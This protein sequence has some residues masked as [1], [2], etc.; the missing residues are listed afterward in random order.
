MTARRGLFVLVALSIAMVVFSATVTLRLQQVVAITNGLIESYD[1]LDRW[2][3]ATQQTPVDQQAVVR[4]AN[5]VVNSLPSV[6]GEAKRDSASFIHFLRQYQTDETA[7]ANAA[8]LKEMLVWDLF[9]CHRLQTQYSRL[10]SLS[11]VGLSILILCI[12]V[13][14]YFM[15]RRAQDYRL[16][17]FPEANPNPVFGL[18]YRGELIYTNVAVHK[19]VATYLGSGGEPTQ[20]LPEGY[21]TQLQELVNRHQLHEVWVHNVHE[22]I[23][24][25][26]LQLLPKH[27]RIHIYAED[28]TE[29]E[30]IRARNAFI[31]Y[32]DPVC[33]L[34]NRQKLEQVIDQSDDPAQPLTLVMTFVSGMS[35]VLSTQGLAVADR[36]A[37]EF[38][39]RLRSAYVSVLTEQDSKPLVFRF[40]ANLF[41]CLYQG[42]L[43]TEVH[44]R[45]EKALDQTVLA[46]F[47]FGK[48]DYFFQIQSGAAS[49]PASV[50]AR[51]LIQRVNLALHSINGCEAVYRVYDHRI[52][53]DIQQQQR[54]EQ[55]LRRAVELDE[56]QMLY[57]PQQDLRSGKLVGFEALMRW[58]L[59][60][61][62][63][64]P[65]EFIPIAERTGLIHSMGNWALRDVF[66]QAI[67]WDA[68]PAIDNTVIAVNV[69][70]S[71]F[72]RRSFIADVKSALNDYPV[73]PQKIQI[74]LTESLLIEDE[75]IAIE[76]MHELKALGFSLAI[77]DFGTGYSSFSYL[78]RFPIDKLKIDR[79][80]IVNLKNGARDLAVVAAM[81]DVAHQLDIEVIA[82]GVEQDSERQ[83]LISLGCDQLQGYFYGRPMS[84]SQATIFATGQTEAL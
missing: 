35:G 2:Q 44:R 76:R 20:L 69:S 83:A 22:H 61:Q 74:E 67:D 55:S 56:L 37:R 58:H 36:F 9:D 54:M 1:A 47:S 14:S 51:Q 84:A 4:N 29:Q 50:S 81:V 72:T 68:L 13:L 78:S 19:A 70:A 25:L 15:G 27:D 26:Q 31:A 43:S 39:I 71:E 77:D 59:K 28:I 34:A 45:L 38:S 65:V 33:M 3:V 40:D 41:G 42:E 73:N 30:E 21:V 52:E 8:E 48:R 63:I 75:S 23:F 62:V 82:E 60:G 46:P 12:G 18:N 24:Q 7:Q 49:A 79:S 11:Q 80:F 10:V 17:P 32:H 64:S 6:I 57:Q 66:K 16:A 5:I 53:A